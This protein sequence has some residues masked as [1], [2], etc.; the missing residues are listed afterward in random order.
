M[1]RL[2]ESKPVRG[3][4]SKEEGD[5]GGETATE[6][7]RS[8]GSKNSRA[9]DYS[10]EKKALKGATTD[11]SKQTERDSTAQHAQASSSSTPAV[12]TSVKLILPAYGSARRSTR[13]ATE[14]AKESTNASA[15]VSAPNDRHRLWNDEVQIFRENRTRVWM[16]R[17]RAVTPYTTVVAARLSIFE[18]TILYILWAITESGTSVYRLF[19]L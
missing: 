14:A 18:F 19:R 16:G 1:K 5:Q 17:R 3:D 2:D 15:V 11:V 13:Q 7:L 9:E 6:A 8:D 12:E 4:D 10:V